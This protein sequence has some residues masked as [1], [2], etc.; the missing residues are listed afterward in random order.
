MPDPRIQVRVWLDQIAAVPG[1]FLPAGRVP[2]LLATIPA[3]D[4]REAEAIFIDLLSR[5]ILEG[6]LGEDLR[7]K[8]E[9]IARRSPHLLSLDEVEGKLDEV[10]LACLGTWLAVIREGKKQPPELKRAYFLTALHHACLPRKAAERKPATTLPDLGAVSTR[11]DER[12][13]LLEFSRQQLREELLDALRPIVPELSLEQRRVWVLN[14]LYGV[15][16]PELV[17]FEGQAKRGPLDN[18]KSRAYDE[19]RER[20]DR[21]RDAF[22]GR[23]PDETVLRAPV[24]LLIAGEDREACEVQPLAPLEC[25]GESFHT[26]LRVSRR[27]SDDH[28]LELAWAI[29]G[30]CDA[31]RELIPSEPFPLTWSKPMATHRARVAQVAMRPRVPVTG[32]VELAR[33]WIFEGDWLAMLT[34]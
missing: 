10:V 33:L 17:W 8:A 12:T 7:S 20:L 4:P 16:M 19:I 24:H 13:P 29:A 18:R 27:E 14:E 28:R 1:S 15:A 31:S 3:D 5:E 9:R 23:S 32:D 22:L 30:L 26:E 2:E 34:S 6:G 25:R 21:V 11:A